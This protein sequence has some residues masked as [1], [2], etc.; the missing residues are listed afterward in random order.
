M[1][2]RESAVVAF[3][4]PADGAFKGVLGGVDVAVVAWFGI[5]LRFEDGDESFCFM[6]IESEVECAWRVR[7][8]FHSF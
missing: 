8:R 6:H 4:D 7:V 2:I 5:A 1:E 3:G